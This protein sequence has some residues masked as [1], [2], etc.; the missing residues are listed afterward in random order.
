L[1]YSRL[2]D[3]GSSLIHIV[4]YDPYSTGKIWTLG[5]TVQCSVHVMCISS[6]R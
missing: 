1:L 5:S 2:V 3:S 6:L 4:A